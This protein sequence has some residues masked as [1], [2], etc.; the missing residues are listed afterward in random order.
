MESDI[1]TVPQGTVTSP[2]GFLA[3]A[4]YAGIKK[5]APG[6]LDLGIL[7]SE[8]PAAAAGVFTTNQVKAAPVIISQQHLQSGQAQAIV[9]NSG[10]A[11]ACTGEPGLADAREMAALAAA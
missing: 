7:F 6:A 4:T 1:T 8:T 5:E 9:A 2:P 10:C 11:N 3:G